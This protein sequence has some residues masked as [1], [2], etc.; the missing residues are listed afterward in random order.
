MLRTKAGNDVHGRGEVSNSK[1]K[2]FGM[3]FGDIMIRF[4]VG[5]LLAGLGPICRY[6][7]LYYI[8]KLIYYIVWLII[9]K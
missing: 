2:V 1:S 3:N 6:I 4:W 8:L 5:Y 9:N 7:I